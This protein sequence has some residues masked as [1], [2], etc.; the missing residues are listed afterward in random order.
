METY[1]IKLKTAK[2]MMLATG[3]FDMLRYINDLQYRQEQRD[4]KESIKEYT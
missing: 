4:L 1:N 3:N 2:G